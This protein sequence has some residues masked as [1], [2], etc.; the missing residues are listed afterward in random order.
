MLYLSNLCR[1]CNLEFK[2]TQTIISPENTIDYNQFCFIKSTIDVQIISSNLNNNYYLNSSLR[3]TGGVKQRN[4][5][6]FVKNSND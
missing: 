6:R 1:L 4:H 2:D 3:Y 5:A